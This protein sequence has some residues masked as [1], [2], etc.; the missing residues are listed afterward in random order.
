MT[1]LGESLSDPVVKVP[2]K[3]STSR[4]IVTFDDNPKFNE[5]GGHSAEESVVVKMWNNGFSLDDGP[6]RLYTDPSSLEFMAA[7]K[8]GRP[9]RVSS[10][11]SL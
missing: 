8:Q 4:P 11:A 1:S 5:E 2:G 7:I 10:K 9:P 6:L 3:Q